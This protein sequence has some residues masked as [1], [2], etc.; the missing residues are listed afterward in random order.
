MK[1]AI[2]EGICLS[3]RKA[4]IE[5]EKIKFLGFEERSNSIFSQTP[6]SKKNSRIFKI[7][8]LCKFLYS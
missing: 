3:E 6:I 4:I 7:T 1:T 5:Q 8:K 2:K